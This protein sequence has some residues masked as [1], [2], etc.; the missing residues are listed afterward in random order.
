ML[1]LERDLTDVIFLVLADG[2]IYGLKIVI[3]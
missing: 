1:Q 2:K 3:F